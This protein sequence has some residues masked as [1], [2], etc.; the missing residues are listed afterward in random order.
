MGR[1]YRPIPE[2]L[3]EKLYFIRRHLDLTQQQIYD[4]LKRGLDNNI[5]PIKLYVSHISEYEREVREPPLEVL[6]EYARIAQIPMEVLVDWTLHLPGTYTVTMLFD[7]SHSI[8]T[9]GRSFRDPNG[10]SKHHKRLRLNKRKS[11]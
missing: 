2:R 5:H 10:V 3:G 9:T 11:P 1:S 7:D 8:L 6:L 4:R